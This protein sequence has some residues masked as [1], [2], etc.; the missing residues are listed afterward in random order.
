MDCWFTSLK[1]ENNENAIAHCNFNL[2]NIN[3]LP[4][5][6]IVVRALL[7]YIRLIMPWNREN[8]FTQ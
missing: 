1:R 6:N 4:V 8:I 3:E 2:I 7:S 5:L